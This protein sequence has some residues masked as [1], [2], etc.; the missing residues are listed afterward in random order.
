MQ[1]FKFIILAVAMSALPPAYGESGGTVGG[2]PAVPANAFTDLNSR[3]IETYSAIADKNLKATRPIL[4]T[5]GFSYLLMCEDGTTKNSPPP[6]PVENQLK[7]VSHLCAYTYAICDAHWR[8]PKDATWKQSMARLQSTLDEAI[9]DA[10]KV[11]W[12]SDAWPHGE[13]KLRDY[14]RKSLTMVR[15]FAAGT[16][17]NGDVT[18][19]EYQSFAAKY[20]PTLETTFYLASLS[21]AFNTRKFLTQWKKEIGNEAW[22]RMRVIISAGKGRSTAGLTAETNPAAVTIASLMSP[23]NFRANVMMDP[24]ASTIDQAL[25]G[26]SLALTSSKLAD[27]IFPTKESQQST[28]MYSALKHPDIPV[29][30][31]PVK[32]AI[33]DLQKGHA[34]DPVLGLGPDE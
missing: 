24:G 32:R 19:P 17:K 4:I 29:A 5:S 23:E 21:N 25:E 22:D 3:F 8:D 31:D 12:A 16:L 26:L 33:S 27:A 9:T 1:L 15:D 10:N 2:G 18:L 13:T 28:W 30:L 34:K 11:S 7:S 20:T 14:I 6:N